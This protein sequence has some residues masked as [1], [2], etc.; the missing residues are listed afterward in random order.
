[1]EDQLVATTRD[2][3]LQPLGIGGQPAVLAWGQLVAFLGR[4]LG[5]DHAALFAEPN[6]N[7]GRGETEWYARV[8][9]VAVPLPSLPARE[10]AAARAELER[11]CAGIRAEAARLSASP[12]A[13]D[14][15]MGGLLGLCLSLPD[16]GHVRVAAGRPVLVAWAHEFAAQGGAAEPLVAARRV[17]GGARGQGGSAPAPLAPA[18]MPEAA[19]AAAAPLRAAGRSRA[20]LV[21]WS[22]LAACLLL[23][24]LL[25]LAWSRRDDGPG[26]AMVAAPVAPPA[27]PASRWAAGDLSLLEGCWTLGAETQATYTEGARTETCKVEAGRLCFGADGKGTR[28][29]A[30]TCPTKGRVSCSAPVEARFADGALATRQPLVTCTPVDTFWNPDEL[31]CRRVGDD[32]ARC[33]DASG[34]QYDFAARRPAR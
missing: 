3:G 22:A 8:D 21:L 4:G 5:P 13:D 20:G 16:E 28:E 11:L 24:L 7:P 14:R 34:F 27:L 18:P 31:S 32:L 2:A 15:F 23:A 30:M 33:I 17:P 19:I 25:A 12:R 10:Q 1:M 26:T 6:P 9:G 29:S